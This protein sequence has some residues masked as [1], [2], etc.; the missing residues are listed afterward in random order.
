MT[1]EFEADD[2]NH[3]AKVRAL[4]D[5]FRRTMVGGTIILAGGVRDLPEALQTHVLAAV[6]A[7]DAFN[8]DHDLWGEHEAGIVEVAGTGPGAN[9]PPL[10]VFFKIECLCPTCLMPT[11]DAAEPGTAIRQITIMLADKR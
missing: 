1:D 7:F 9:T 10:R 11:D 2:T 8:P 4:N 6:Q 5:A 3:T